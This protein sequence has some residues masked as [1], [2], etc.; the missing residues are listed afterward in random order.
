MDLSEMNNALYLAFNNGPVLKKT[1]RKWSVVVGSSGKDDH[2]YA[3][4][5]WLGSGGTEYF[6][7]A[8]WIYTQQGG[9]IRKDRSSSSISQS[10]HCTS[11]WLSLNIHST[12]SLT[13]RVSGGRKGI[14]PRVLRLPGAKPPSGGFRVQ[15]GRVLDGIPVISMDRPG[16]SQRVRR[17][18]GM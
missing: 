9:E 16:C 1:S 3:W 7:D 14:S 6:R 10:A 17:R 12:A 2:V 13:P 11:E 15:W 5:V 8:Y 18:T 4:D